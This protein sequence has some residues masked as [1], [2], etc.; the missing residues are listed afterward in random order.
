MSTL[1]KIEFDLVNKYFI[2]FSSLFNDDSDTDNKA[3]QAFEIRGVEAVNKLVAEFN[4]DLVDQELTALVLG[5]LNDLQVRDY[6]MG[7][8]TAENLNKLNN[9]WSLLTAVAPAGA[10]APVATLWAISDY[11]MGNTASAL[12]RLDTAKADQEDYS[13]A[14]LIGRVIS[15]GWPVESFTAM[16]SELHHKVV[17]GIYGDV[18]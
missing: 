5:S 3:I 1:N 11:E 6:C 4:G 15:A 9:L 13:L 16:R 17:A 18:K 12:E 10:I 2:E 7:I 14:K 8:T